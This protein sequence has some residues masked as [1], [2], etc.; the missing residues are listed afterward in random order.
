MGRIVD[1]VRNVQNLEVVVFLFVAGYPHPGGNI[2]GVNDPEASIRLLLNRKVE[3]N[4]AVS[5]LRSLEGEEVAKGIQ[6][7]RF[8]LFA[9]LVGSGQPLGALYNMRVSAD[10]DVY[11]ALNKLLRKRFLIA[12]GLKLV[13]VPQCMKQT[14][15]SAPASLK[16]FASLALLEFFTA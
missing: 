14:I 8:L 4:A 10:D 6:A 1:I 3:D 13:L 7:Q 12:V 9:K 5:V 2:A 16:A 11:A 15:T